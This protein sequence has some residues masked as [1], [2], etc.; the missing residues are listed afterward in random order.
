MLEIVCLNVGD[1]FPDLYVE[2]L[3]NM[4]SRHVDESFQL[5]CFTDRDRDL[6][7]A[8]KQSDCSSWGYSGWF[9][10]VKLFDIDEMPS[11][12]FLYFDVSLVIRSNLRRLID[13]AAKEKADLIAV[14]DWNHDVLNSCVMRIT[15]SE[16]S[17]VI[18]EAFRDEEY[19][20]EKF[21]GDQ[22]FIDAVIRRK[23]RTSQLKYFP[24]E[25]I[26]SY[27]SL[28]KLHRRKPREAAEM[29]ENGMVL[30]FHGRPRMADLLSPMAF[31][32]R[33]TCRYP[34]WA[35]KD[36]MYLS[37]EVREQWK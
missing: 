16:T 10:K 17:Q 26:L 20:D 19:G 18:W 5:T 21:S 12:E 23:N 28:L 3:F 32:K 13:F 14:R 9:N 4:L 27:K 24:D 37:E 34:N 35:F 1:Q 2:R 8:V 31:L 7:A 6:P 15:R 29:L 36:W 25:F 22:N 30:K 11:S 33:V